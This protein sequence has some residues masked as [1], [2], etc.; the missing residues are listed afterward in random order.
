MVARISLVSIFLAAALGLAG[1]ALPAEDRSHLFIEDGV[2]LFAKGDY[3][4]ALESFDMALTLHPQDPALL[5]NKAECY[6]RLGSVKRAEEYYLYCLQRAP[7]NAD[8]R[9]ALVALYYRSDQRPKA[10]SIVDEALR[11]N[12]PTA[13]A[14]VLDAWRLRQAKDLPH[15][16]A[17]AQQALDLE[18]HN[19]RARMEMALIFEQLGLPDR[20][21]VLYERILRQEPNRADVVA[22]LE[23]L[24]AQGTRR[25][26]PD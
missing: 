6:D 22:R 3:Q 8:A 1:C 17:R 15:A 10:D 21:Y 19:R 7:D 14:F 24:K 26:R 11:Q 16:E 2:E 4:N 12:P 5:F 20:A 18:P 25:P 23:L 13:D 9:L